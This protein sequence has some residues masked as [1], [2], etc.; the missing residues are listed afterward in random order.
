MAEVV[1]DSRQLSER[2]RIIGELSRNLITASQNSEAFGKTIGKVIEDLGTGGI[3]TA[4]ETAELASKAHEYDRRLQQLRDSLLSLGVSTKQVDKIITS[5]DS[6]LKKVS[7]DFNTLYQQLKE[8]K[9]SVNGFINSMG[10]WGNAISALGKKF[11]EFVTGVGAQFAILAFLAKQFK[12][13]TMGSAQA[14][15][16]LRVT[17][18]GGKGGALSM[19]GQFAA[20]QELMAFGKGLAFTND[21]I[22]NLTRQFGEL[23]LASE[24]IHTSM[25][26]MRVLGMSA[27]QAGKLTQT[28]SKQFGLSGDKLNQSFLMIAATANSASIPIDIVAKATEELAAVQIGHTSSLKDSQRIV[29]SLSQAF[30]NGKLTLQ[31]FQQ[32]VKSSAAAQEGISRQSYGNILGFAQ[33]ARQMGISL[34]KT[35]Q[36]K[37]EPFALINGFYNASDA[38]RTKMFLQVSNK[39]ASQIGGDRLG[40]QRMVAKNFGL[41]PGE[42][43]NQSDKQFKSTMDALAGGKTIEQIKEGMS[44]GKQDEFKDVMSTSEKQL[45][46]IATA[47]GAIQ[48]AISQI[49]SGKAIHTIIDVLENNV[50]EKNT[51]MDARSEA[52]NSLSKQLI[53]ITNAENALKKRPDSDPNKAR[54]E[55]ELRS[56]KSEV[57][58]AMKTESESIGTTFVK[59]LPAKATKRGIELA[60]ESLGLT[61]E[62]GNQ[63]QKMQIE[64]TDSLSKGTKFF[65]SEIDEI[66]EKARKKLEAYQVRRNG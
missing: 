25:M 66:L 31:E 60:S 2:L 6:E 52:R 9:I 18:T 20:A 11:T 29:L 22:V 54:L 64:L 36:G 55:R 48:G 40:T 34:P 32:A 53:G 4:R 63:A 28:F 33:M 62:L 13:I 65:K 61:P 15:N 35:M 44:K 59:E 24:G 41:L 42:V 51:A 12:D 16:Q 56:Q 30:S 38:E 5:I 47:S 23:G 26:A 3:K 21:E 46:T 45:M 1:D 49:L 19:T 7:A 37:T 57:M 17:N 43:L 8:G 58:K 27:E 14:V 39:L 50:N 10:G